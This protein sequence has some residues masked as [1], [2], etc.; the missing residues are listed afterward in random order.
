MENNESIPFIKSIGGRISLMFALLMITGIAAVAVISVLQS[1]NALTDASFNQLRAIREIK[2]GQ[3]EGYFN[4][5]YAD[6]N[7]LSNMLEAF[8]QRSF[9]ELRTIQQA[10][11]NELEAFFSDNGGPGLTAHLPPHTVRI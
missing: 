1:G 6:M 3:V 5:R 11:N 2:K 4:E 8:K 10:R 7:V 9:G